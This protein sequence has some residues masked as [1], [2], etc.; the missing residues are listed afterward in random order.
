MDNLLT[1]EQVAK[2]LNIHVATVRKLCRDGRLPCVK[3]LR[4]W[5]IKEAELNDKIKK[6]DI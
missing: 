1:V 6:G 3:M 4:R 2:K 5:H